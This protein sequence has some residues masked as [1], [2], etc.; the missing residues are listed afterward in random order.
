MPALHLQFRT[1]RRRVLLHSSEAKVQPLRDLPAVWQAGLPTAGRFVCR[2]RRAVR[3]RGLALRGPDLI[4]T[5]EG[6][7]HELDPFHESPPVDA[8]EFPPPHDWTDGGVQKFAEPLCAV[9]ALKP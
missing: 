7:F 5:S 3:S 9:N 2:P 8:H 1:E 6:Q 4:G